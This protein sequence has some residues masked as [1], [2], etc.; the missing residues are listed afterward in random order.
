[1]GPTVFTVVLLLL[2]CYCKS[3]ASSL[4]PSGREVCQCQSWGHYKY[5]LRGGVDHRLVIAKN[6][7]VQGLLVS[8]DPFLRRK[9]QTQ[10]MQCPVR[11]EPLMDRRQ[12]HLNF[13]GNWE[14]KSCMFQVVRNYGYS[15]LPGVCSQILDGEQILS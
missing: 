12:L 10:A 2:Y 9:G 14:E 15:Q 5:T 6:H 3:K 11:N 1:M 4:P 7:L 8:P 13:I